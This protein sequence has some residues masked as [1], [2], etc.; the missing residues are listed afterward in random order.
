MIA[1]A[2]GYMFSEA[3]VVFD[4]DLPVTYVRLESYKSG[5]DEAPN[6]SGRRRSPRTPS[7]VLGQVFFNV[8]IVDV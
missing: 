8:F 5:L 2:L 7:G 1:I 4:Y 6:L 3:A